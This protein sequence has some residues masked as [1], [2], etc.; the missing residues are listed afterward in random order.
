M[1]CFN[2]LHNDYG[3]KMTSHQ[4]REIKPVENEEDL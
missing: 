1:E 2:K 4:R 3:W